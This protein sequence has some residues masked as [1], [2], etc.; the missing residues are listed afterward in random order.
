VALRTEI[1]ALRAKT[2]DQTALIA[3]LQTLLVRAGPTAEA[4]EQPAGTNGAHEAMRPAKVMAKRRTAAD[5]PPPLKAVDSAPEAA[6]AQTLAEVRRLKAVSQ[7]QAAEISGSG[8]A[9][10][11]RDVADG[12]AKKQI[13]SKRLRP[14]YR[15]VCNQALRRGRTGR[16]CAR[17]LGRDAPPW[18]G[19]GPGFRA[20][21]AYGWRSPGRAIEA[22]A[23]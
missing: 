16:E 22:P 1:E 6:D 19:H 21:A 18:I 8:G 17:Q 23:G 7:D 14:G 9:R 20:D 2:R 12:A 15:G 4:A 3:R 13:A 10:H 11:L 5:G